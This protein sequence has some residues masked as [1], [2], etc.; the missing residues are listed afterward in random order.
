MNPIIIA[1]RGNSGEAPE[2]TMAAFSQLSETGAGGVEFDVQASRDGV[3]MVIHDETL[4]RTTDGSGAVA[5]F[6]AAQLAQ[7]DAGSWFAPEFRG[8]SIPK[9]AEV[10]DLFSGT[11]LMI[12]IEFKTTINPYAGLVPSVVALVRERSMTHRVIV[13]SFNHN[14][15]LELEQHAPEIFRAALSDTH[16]AEPWDYCLR[17]RFAAYHPEKHGCGKALIDRCH[18]EGLAVRCYTVDDTDE[19][20]RLL[21]MGIDGLFTNFPR[22]LGT[23]LDS[24][25]R[26][27]PD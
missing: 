1:H 8:E 4:N 11:G 23:L 13:S 15:L 24:Q 18:E 14:T 12:N 9:L 25:G 19:A 26:L 16:L 20:M 21:Q 6:S 22:R 2:N 10:L 3:P 27:P 5:E 7:L 17:N